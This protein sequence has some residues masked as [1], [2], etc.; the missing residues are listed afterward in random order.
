MD[1]MAVVASFNQ[2]A[3]RIEPYLSLDEVRFSPTAQAIDFSNLIEGG[4]RADQDRALQE[5]IVR[6]SAKADRWCMG[7]YGTLNA[8]VNTEPIETRPN[9]SA[10]FVVHPWFTPILEI[11]AF[12]WGYDASCAFSVPLTPQ[13]CFIQRDYF[14]VLMT[15]NTSSAPV[16]GLGG[17]VWSSEPGEIFANYT[18][19]NGYANT[20]TTSTTA[21]GAT[22]I[23][24]TDP[25]GIYPGMNI[26][27]WDG[28]NDEYVQVS[29]TYQTGSTTVTLVSPLQ[30]AHGS[31]VNVS[32]LPADVKQ[33]VIHFVVALIKQ[34]GQSGLVLS[35][36]GELTSQGGRT[37]SSS[38]DDQLAYDLLEPYRVVWGQQ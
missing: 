2:Q 31:G 34:R 20:F 35:D 12:N 29:P 24:V 8:T 5:L 32:A 9:R 17:L 22:S 30:Y 38:A 10:E 3:G 14:K 26:S 7:R 23:N 36:M 19:V 6:A 4:G 1:I 25:T 37:E 15:A 11:R 13:N 18:Y 33:A 21:I 28:I 16:Y 27:V